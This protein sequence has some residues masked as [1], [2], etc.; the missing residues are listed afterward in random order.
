M[1]LALAWLCLALSATVHAE[2]P[3]PA[4]SAQLQRARLSL[5]AGKPEALAEAVKA[6]Q[7]APLA[8]PENL[9]AALALFDSASFDDAARHLRRAL[10]ADPDALKDEPNLDQR[11][12][13]DHINARLKDLAPLIEADS[14]LCFLAGT[15]MLLRGDR[16]RAVP[17][18]V[19]AEELAGTDAQ[20]NALSARLSSTPFADRNRTRAISSLR[21]GGF[22][23]AAR[24]FSF[25]A[26]DFPTLAEH[27]AGAAV[28]HSLAG[29]LPVA[30]RMCDLMIARARYERLLPWV[31]DLA[32][33]LAAAFAATRAAR[34]P[35]A[36]TA[37]LSELRLAAT[38]ALSAGM[39]RTAHDAAVAA[40]LRD[41]LDIFS[42]ELLSFLE[43]SQL[44]NDPAGLPTEPDPAVKPPLPTQ[45][46]QPVEPAPDKPGKPVDEARKLIRRLE[47]TE[48]LK[49]L[50][51]LVGTD[52][53]DNAVL[54]L[55]F[56]ASVGRGE[57]QPGADALQAWW[58]KATE[59][60]RTRLNALRELFDRAEHFSQWRNQILT[61]RQ[62]DANASLPR[63]LNAYVELSVGAYASA[64]QE[65]QVALIGAPENDMLRQMQKLLDKDEYQRDALAPNLGDKPTAKMLLGQADTLFRRG[66]YDAARGVLLLAQEANPKEPKLNEALLRVNFACGDY[67]RAARLFETLLAEQNIGE[68]AATDFEF[69]MQAGYDRAAEFDKHLEALKKAASER[70]SAA[71]EY[72]V[73]GAIYFT[74][75]NWRDAAIALQEWKGLSREKQLNA[76]LLKLLEA[77]QKKG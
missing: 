56:V 9:H 64:R 60:D 57:P 59:A 37:G 38:I 45:P 65:V 42:H 12:P 36:K 15:L 21:A 51:P 26:L 47:F 40:L 24:S 50:D 7:A 16:A 13:A 77:A 41:K 18:L 39:Y 32:S 30:L 71:D 34:A 33:P 6:L 31:K 35:A 43:K 10:A 66:E 62:A 17:L 8:A 52:Q 73:L 23:D 27:Y 2:G 55:V 3:T 61:L 68:K 28:G 48:A 53:K 4:A 22:D 67:T 14:E 70:T 19:R 44:E 5:Q 29:D 75:G 46:D 49:L 69:S 63:L 76:A 72:L 58:A 54:L 25:A 1:P 11:L 20:A 74:R